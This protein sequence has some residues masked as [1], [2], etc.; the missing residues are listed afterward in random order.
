MARQ[1]RGRLSSID[2][3]P[4]CADADIAWV[5]GEL[6]A[7][8]RL[9]K[10]ILREFNARIA[11][12]GLAPVS[13]GAFSRYSVRKAE[14]FRKLDEVR[15]ISSNLVENLGVQ[16][17]DD[18]TMLVAQMIKGMAYNILEAGAVD[19]KGVMEL[20]RGVRAAVQAQ[21]LSADHRERMQKTIDKKSEEVIEKVAKEAGL[22]GDRINQLRRDFLG[23]REK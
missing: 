15:R 2:L 20:A 7:N 19:T 6:R 21:R 22:S 17:P 1:G 8:K 4:E 3:L 10:D 16:G 18:V 14:Q 12:H 5:S 13:V 23:V 9:Q 11:D